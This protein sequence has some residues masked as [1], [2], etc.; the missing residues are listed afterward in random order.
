MIL[1]ASEKPWNKDLVE[2]L[3]ESNSGFEFQLISGKEQMNA[4]HLK[5]LNPEKIFFPHWSHIIPT[6][7]HQE[8]DCIVFH[9]TDLPFGRGGSPLQNLIV[10]GYTETVISALRVVK[11]IDAGPVYLK[12]PLS[13]KGTAKEIFE[14]ADQ[15]IEEMILEILK[16]NPKPQEQKGEVVEFKRRTPSDGQMNDLDNLKSIFDYIRMLDAPT[17]PKAYVELEHVKIEFT[18]AKLNDDE[19]VEAN[20]RIVKK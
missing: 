17:Y 10:R 13:L 7:I 9:M 3:N 2:R 20:V 15:I 16:T 19:S 1:I 4:D 14:R 12:T 18:N 8:Y 6:E 5:T 11:E